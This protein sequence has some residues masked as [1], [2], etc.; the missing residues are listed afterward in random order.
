MKISTPT[1]SETSNEIVIRIPKRWVGHSESRPLTEAQV[2]RFV[3]AGTREF[4]QGKTKTF[5]AFLA[6]AHPLHARISRRTR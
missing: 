2:L 4:R 5:G 6:N 1:I 3:A